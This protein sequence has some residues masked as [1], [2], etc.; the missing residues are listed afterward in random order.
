MGITKNL[1][2]N[3]QDGFVSIIVTLIMIIIITLIVLAFA[4]LSRRE[5]RA[6]LDRH[7]S[8]QAFYAAESGINDLTASIRANPGGYFSPSNNPVS[9]DCADTATMDANP[10]L[11]INRV[12]DA[13]SNVEYSCLLYDTEVD[14]L[15]FN[16]VSM[17]KS[18]VIPINNTN[19]S[20]ISLSWWNDSGDT[21]FGTGPVGQFT[22]S[23]SWPGDAGVLRTI[24]IPREIIGR[25]N[26][27]HNTFHGFFYPVNAAA[28]TTGTATLASG[29]GLHES[30]V[31][32]QANCNTG[33][34]PRFCNAEITGLGGTDGWYLVLRSIY[35]DSQVIVRCYNSSNVL[36]T[37]QGS[38]VMID[39]TG[40][41][42]D[43][44]RRIQVRKNLNNISDDTPPIGFQSAESICKMIKVTPP[45]VEQ[46]FDN[47]CPSF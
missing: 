24:L 40:K 34:T 23:G 30:G 38:Q 26:Y 8:T 36:V 44:T 6:S 13:S 35:R 29:I 17:N 4:Q 45:Q 28:N 14:F 46:D 27:L 20:R 37:C 19:L 33:S 32:A 15:E 16:D 42:G 12:I 25:G 22:T 41:A 2:I 7:L 3:K 5:Q 18:K 21:N 11:N 47:V 10:L 1:R 31:I 39:A 9:N 43:V